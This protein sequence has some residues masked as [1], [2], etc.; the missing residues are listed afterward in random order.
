MIRHIHILLNREETPEGRLAIFD[1]FG[2]DRYQEGDLLESVWAGHIEAETDD[3]ALA[4]AFEMFNAGAPGFIGST[5]YPHRSLSVGDVV[6]VSGIRYSCEPIGWN[7]ITRA[8]TGK[9]AFL[10]RMR[11]S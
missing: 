1:R 2:E 9:L 8:K 10:R 3:D 6:E 4:L 5:E 11:K 7:R